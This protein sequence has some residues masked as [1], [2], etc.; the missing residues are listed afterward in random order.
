M[1]LQH[2]SLSGNL[3]RALW[4]GAATGAVAMLSACASV[5][6]PSSA[7]VN[8]PVV[9]PANAAV[10]TKTTTPASTHAGNCV[11]SRRPPAQLPRPG[12]MPAGSWM[13]HIQQ[14]GH[15]IAGVDQ[16]TFLWGYRDPS[17]NQLEGFDIDML[18]AVSRAIFGDARPVA[19]VVVPN[20]D[21]EAAVKSGR[22]DV[23][24][25]T[26]T[27]T[28][29]RK[30][31]VDFSAVYYQAG[32]EILVP[33]HSPLT[34][35][36]QTW[37]GQRMC[38]VAGSTSLQHLA[39]VPVTPPIV[40]VSVTNQTDC[41]VLLQQ[42][43]VAAISTDD[44]ILQGMAAQDPTLRIVGP[45][46]APEPYGMAVSKQHPEF[47]AFVNGVLAQDAGHYWERAYAKWLEPYTHLARPPHQ[48]TPTYSSSGK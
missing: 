31:N 41:L 39:A 2:Q 28:C 34:G 27:I 1:T 14:R 18:Q 20:A 44:T 40:P 35:N 32:Q 4:L 19:F 17:T 13:A 33:V 10:V 26:M 7:P 30:K 5:S 37:A 3:V 36:R 6:P 8:V 12:S 42:G 45:P 22:V 43:Q 48:P 24:A 11:A 21:R 16:N 29:K 9:A 23:L 46:L 25:E 47:T 15:L 38:A